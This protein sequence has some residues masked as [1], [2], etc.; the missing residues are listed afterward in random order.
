MRTREYAVWCS[1][2]ERNVAEA[3]GFFEACHA[4]QGHACD[5]MDVVVV[6]NDTTVWDSD[7]QGERP[8]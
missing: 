8:R 2:C 1:S 6:Y 7:G 3:D 4:A 5:E